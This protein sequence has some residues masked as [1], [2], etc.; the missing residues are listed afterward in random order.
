MSGKYERK[1][2]KKSGPKIALIVVIVVLVLL[3]AVAAAVVVYY[4]TMLGKMNQVNVP[5]INYTQAVTEPAETETVPVEPTETVAT[6]TT[7][8]PT[9]PHVA[10]RDWRDLRQDCDR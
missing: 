1:K 2:P 9:Q 8:P 6:E 10:S 4:N 5:K 3:L 7:V